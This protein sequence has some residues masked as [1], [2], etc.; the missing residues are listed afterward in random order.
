[1]TSYKNF[2]LDLNYTLF[3]QPMF[4]TLI[5]LCK[6][7]YWDPSPPTCKTF[8]FGGFNTFIFIQIGDKFSFITIILT[9]RF[10]FFFKF[11][12]FSPAISFVM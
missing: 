1:M 4:F 11:D 6:F 5:F 7:F 9:L 8:T 12:A 2:Y 10:F 3:C